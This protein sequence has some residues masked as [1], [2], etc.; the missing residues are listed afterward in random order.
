[1]VAA[2]GDRYVRVM[3]FEILGEIQDPET[4]ARGTKVRARRRL[5]KAYGSGRWRKRKGFARIELASGDVRDAEIHWYETSGIG[6][7]EFKIKRFLE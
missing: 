7:R 3:Y 2:G 6:Q 5:R 4:I 1:M